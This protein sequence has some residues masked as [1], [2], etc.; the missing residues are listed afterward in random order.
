[1]SL[2]IGTILSLM[3]LE[4]PWRYLAIVPLA[5][6]EAFEIYLWM[7]WRRVRSITGPEAFVGSTGRAVTDCRPEGQVRVKGALW[8]AHCPAGVDAGERIVVEAMDGMLLTVRPRDVAA[9]PDG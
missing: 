2:I 3:F 5:A 8:R 4:S 9:R 1:M 6:W 7:K